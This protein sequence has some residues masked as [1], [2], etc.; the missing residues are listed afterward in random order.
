MKIDCSNDELSTEEDVVQEET[1]ETN[2]EEE[3]I[4]CRSTRDRRCPDYYGEWANV[5][6]DFNEPSTVEEA[7][8]SSDREKWKVAINTEFESLSTNKVWELVPLPKDGK[9]FSKT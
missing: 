4:V 1:T 6:D 9:V 8:S 7:L 5:A 3:P 2:Q